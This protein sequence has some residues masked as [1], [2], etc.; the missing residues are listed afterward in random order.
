MTVNVGSGDSGGAVPA[1]GK[2]QGGAA[3][4]SC[5]RGLGHR[6]GRGSRGS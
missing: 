5:W 1:A 3:A 2:I 4:G 6:Q